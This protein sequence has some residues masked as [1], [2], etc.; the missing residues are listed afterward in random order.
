[1][2]KE[3]YIGQPLIVKETGEKVTFAYDNEEEE[4]PYIVLHA[5]NYF[6]HQIG[7]ASCRE[8]V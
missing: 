1:M 6:S 3:F 4:T 8:R 7:R 5:D 2:N